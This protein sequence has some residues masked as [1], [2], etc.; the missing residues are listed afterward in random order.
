ME[1]KKL[2]KIKQFLKEAFCVDGEVVDYESV[3]VTKSATNE[4]QKG[5]MFTLN[6]SKR[7]KISVTLTP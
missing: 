2:I 3:I 4:V 5:V 1:N 6:D 7:G